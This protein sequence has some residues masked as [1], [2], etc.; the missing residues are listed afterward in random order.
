MGMAC[1]IIRFPGKLLLSKHGRAKAPGRISPCYN[2]TERALK[3][4]LP[5]QP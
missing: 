4:E 2:L 1:G 5:K 3:V